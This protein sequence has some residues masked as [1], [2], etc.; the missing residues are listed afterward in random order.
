MENVSARTG[1]GSAI[2]ESAALRKG[3]LLWRFYKSY[4]WASV[5]VSLCCAFFIVKYG[6]EALIPLLWFKAATAALVVYVVRNYKAAE[7]HYYKNLGLSSVRLWGV[8]LSFDFA[9]F[10]LLVVIADLLRSWLF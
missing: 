8:T 4:A 3:R 5:S 9:L 2:S 6:L 10:V 1:K 7:F